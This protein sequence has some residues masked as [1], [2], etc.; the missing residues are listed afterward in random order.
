MGKGVGHLQMGLGAETVTGLQQLCHKAPCGAKIRN[1]C[2]LRRARKENRV[3]QESSRNDKEW[4]AEF[5]G[6]SLFSQRRRIS[7]QNRASCAAQ[8]LAPVGRWGSPVLLTCSK[9]LFAP[10]IPS[11]SV[12]A[13]DC[14]SHYAEENESLIPFPSTHSLSCRAAGSTHGLHGRGPRHLSPSLVTALLFLSLSLSSFKATNPLH[15]KME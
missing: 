7:H 1:Q 5:R 12:L 14:A 15:D 3:R 4:G 6:L 8:I 10:R 13:H 9:L 11:P 2:I